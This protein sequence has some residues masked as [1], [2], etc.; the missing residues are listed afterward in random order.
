M[1]DKWIEI[2][3]PNFYTYFSIKEIPRSKTSVKIN[4]LKNVA[5]WKV[6]CTFSYNKKWFSGSYLYTGQ[7][8]L[9]EDKKDISS[10]IDKKNNY[11]L[12]NTNIKYYI[13]NYFFDFYRI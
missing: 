9:I 3:V 2:N 5:L 6:E 7:D 1:M 13:I 12:N 4:K 8:I 11:L 10:D